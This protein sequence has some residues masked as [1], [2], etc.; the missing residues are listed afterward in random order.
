[1]NKVRINE[2]AAGYME[3]DGAQKDADCQVIDV[4]GA[5]LRTRA[6]V[7]ISGHRQQR[8]LLAERAFT[9]KTRARTTSRKTGSGQSAS[10]RPRR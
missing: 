10:A 5:S 7:I 8:S 4:A 2:R 3:L 9:S 1:M 6:V